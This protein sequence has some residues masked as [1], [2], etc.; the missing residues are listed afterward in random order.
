LRVT[1]P[2][3][4]TQ[5]FVGI[6][7]A[8]AVDAYL[9]DV[10]HD[11]ITG[12][13]DGGTPVYLT[14][15]GSATVS[16]PTEQTFWTAQTS[17]PGTRQLAWSPSDGRWSVVIM[18]ADGSPSIAAAVTVEIKAGL[19][20][21]LA[22]TLLVIGVVITLGAVALIGI[23]AVGQP[24]NKRVRSWSSDSSTKDDIVAVATADPRLP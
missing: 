16:A 6:G 11:E 19:L 23:G 21:P 15:A 24:G 10:A 13:I 2:G 9:A 5:T 8:V 20:L 1:A 4:D 7:P 3:S 12:V 22:L 14:R 17:G 18:N